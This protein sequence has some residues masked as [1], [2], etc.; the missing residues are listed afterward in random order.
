[1]QMQDATC[2]NFGALTDEELDFMLDH[3]G[4]IVLLVFDSCIFLVI[5][6]L[7]N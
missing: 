7:N 3:N 2:L 4:D 6:F 5:I 1:M